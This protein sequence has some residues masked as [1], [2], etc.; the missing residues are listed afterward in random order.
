MRDAA[1]VRMPTTGAPPPLP[2]LAGAGG[3]DT[4]AGGDGPTTIMV[5]VVTGRVRM[6]GL[7]CGMGCGGDGGT[8]EVT[9]TGGGVISTVVVLKTTD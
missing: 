9:I 8:T 1:S 5:E 6:P 4:A 7:G 2:S 3:A